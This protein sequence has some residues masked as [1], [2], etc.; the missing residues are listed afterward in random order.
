[1]LVDS[2]FSGV[3]LVA[4]GHDVTLRKAYNTAG[5]RLTPQSRFWIGSMPKGFTAAAILRLV[6]QKRLALSDSI[7]RLIPDAPAD[8]RAITIRELLTHT[9]GIDGTSAANGKTA[10]HDAVTAILAQAVVSAPGS[11]YRYMDDDYVLLAAIVE[12]ASGA[13]WQDYVRRELLSRAGLRHTSF[14]P[15]EDWGHV[16]ANGMSSTADDVFRWTLALRDGRVLNAA[17]SR[18]TE[19]GQVFVR[20]ERGAD[21]YYGYGVRV[22]EKNGTVIEVIAFRQLRRSEYR[23]RAAVA[24]KFA[25]NCLI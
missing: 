4:H 16:G 11:R 6:E 25:G 13:K 14:W 22:Y 8:K 1:M 5:N 7:G 24:G 3:V 9:S 2:G 12:V 19:T 18:L 23:N 15:G 20:Q 17:N 10:R 21:I